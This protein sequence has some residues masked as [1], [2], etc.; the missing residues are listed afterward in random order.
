MP[1]PARKSLSVLNEVF[2]LMKLKYIAEKPEKS[3]TK[4]V[5]DYLLMNIERDVFLSKYA[6]F[7][8]KIGVTDN[9]MY[10]KDS[11]KNK[12][13]EIRIVNG[14]LQSNDDDPIYTQ[15]AISMPELSRLN[16]KL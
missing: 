16:K 5:S 3:F 13:I 4:W 7:I 2:N 15:Y 8:S 11:K 9:V 14:I 10:L 1:D 6:P 12:V